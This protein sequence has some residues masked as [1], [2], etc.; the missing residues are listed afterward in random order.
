VT[1]VIFDLDGVLVD[2]R[3]AISGAMNHALEANGFP[4]LAPAELYRFIGP[5]LGTGFVEL[6]GQ[7]M[8]SDAV[9]A[10]LAAYRERYAVTSLTETVVVDGIPG[11]LDV[12]R[13][14]HRLAVATS[15]LRALAEP[16]LDALGL[17]DRFEVVAGPDLNARGEDKATTIAAAL[18]AL[19]DDNAVMIGD[20]AFDLVG[21][22]ANGLPAI[23]VTW[24]IGT[25]EELAAAD[26]L[27]DAPADLPDS[28]AM[29][30][31]RA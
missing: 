13:R 21:A 16:L 8:E 6:T 31:A 17:R 25:R 30:L 11:A 5:P 1:A 26:A 23:G 4:R 2:S 3:A 29:L 22:R 12:L 24:G 28:V 15:K 27:L 20:T 9:A 18:A 10:C 19:A 7:P 14:D